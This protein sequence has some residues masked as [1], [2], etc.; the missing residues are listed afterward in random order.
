MTQSPVEER[1]TDAERELLIVLLTQA[2]ERIKGDPAMRDVERQCID[3]LGK[4][5]GVYTELVARR[6]YAS[7]A[8]RTSQTEPITVH[9]LHNG[10]PLCR[11]N[12]NVPSEWPEGHRWIGRDA[13]EDANCPACRKVIERLE[14]PKSWRST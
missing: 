11:F 5:N 12:A 14:G 2:M 9:I 4:L 8:P 3:M 10:R 13:V 1:F 6:A 7:R